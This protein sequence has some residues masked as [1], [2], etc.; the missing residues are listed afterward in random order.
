MILGLGNDIIEIERIKTACR[1]HSDRFLKR[2]FT[3]NEC[4]YCQSFNDS[5]PHFAGRYAAKEAIAKAF[6]CGF[7]E[8][9]SW[10]DI[11]ILAD[12][13]GRPIVYFSDK[14]IKHFDSPKMM[15]SISHTKDYATA[16]AIWTK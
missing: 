16:I 3:E 12:K 4:S 1:E 2:I 11:E 15:V 8:Q 9:L 14:V 10:H 13:L 6:G 5:F 7:G